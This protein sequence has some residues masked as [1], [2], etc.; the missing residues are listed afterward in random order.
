MPTYQLTERQINSI[1]KSLK[2]EKGQNLQEGVWGDIGMELL[3]VVDPT[4]IV[5]IINGVRY[6]SRGDYLFGTLSFISAIPFL[7]DIVA[8]PVMGA[9][10]IGGGAASTLKKAEA[11]AKAGKTVEASAELAKA[12]KEPGVIGAFLRKAGDWA[13]KV[14]NR[15][16]ILPG[17]LLKGFK[18]TISDWL[19]LIERAGAKSTKFASEAGKLAQTAN[20][21]AVKQLDNIKEL[22][23]F[24]KTSKVWDTAALTKRGPLSQIFMGGAP[25]LF[26]DRR[27]R[28]L[29]R[30]TKYWLGF[31]DWV[32][33]VD[34]VSPEEAIQQLG[35][36]D[37]VKK[38]LEEYNKTEEAERYAREDFSDIT[39][40]EVENKPENTVKAPKSDTDITDILKS[41]FSNNLGRAALALL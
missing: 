3:G 40:S 4:G 26:G 11:F 12:A 8:K 21:T 33:I 9:L 15:L 38:K 35:G 14:K 32:G 27:M 29:I 31:L 28:I 13:P 18:N 36:E 34:A 17:G 25:R 20:I 41:L 30:Q 10:R 7:G 37:T 2:K 16:D 6:F 1:A 24:L 22:Q 5:D 23:N 39:Q 19:T